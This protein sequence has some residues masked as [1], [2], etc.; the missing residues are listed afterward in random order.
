MATFGQFRSFNAA[1]VNVGYRIG[2]PSLGQHA[3]YFRSW[4]STDTTPD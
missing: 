4:P 3:S 1:A 2:K